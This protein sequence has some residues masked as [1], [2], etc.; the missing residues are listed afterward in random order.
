MFYCHHSHLVCSQKIKLS[1]GMDI[2]WND[3]IVEWE[4]VSP[5]MAI[6]KSS[7]LLMMAGLAKPRVNLE[8]QTKAGGLL[9]AN[10]PL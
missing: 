3:G 1:Y 4:E 5:Q 8:I 2:I 10:E 7:L 6:D 9:R